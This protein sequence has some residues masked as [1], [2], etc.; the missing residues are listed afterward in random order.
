M[1]LE[2]S[3][4]SIRSAAVEKGGLVT[5]VFCQAI[6]PVAPLIAGDEATAG[7]ICQGLVNN[8]IGDHAA[9][10][11]LWNRL[12]GGNGAINAGV[13]ARIAF[14][15]KTGGRGVNGTSALYQLLANERF[16]AVKGLIPW[17]HP[18][19]Q[20][21]SRVGAGESYASM[22]K[23]LATAVTS[24]KP[25]DGAYLNIALQ[26]S[27]EAPGG[28]AVGAFVGGLAKGTGKREVLFFDPNVGEFWFSDSDK[29]AAW[30][31]MCLMKTL[32][33][34]ANY[35]YKAFSISAFA[36]KARGFG[37]KR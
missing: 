28:H 20:V 1:S 35:K 31:N 7:G 12:Y 10:G 37:K 19:L 24:F 22:A 4:A 6:P 32:T 15:Q 34:Q 8:W 11:S 30:L 26:H 21:Y 29:F 18:V 25:S 36:S 17:A 2:D 27:S 3:L 13:V 16:L 9:G 5:R 23:L 33:Q 14:E